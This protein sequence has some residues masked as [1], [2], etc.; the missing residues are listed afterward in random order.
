MPPAA[1]P[2]CPHTLKHVSS[3]CADCSCSASSTILARAAVSRCCRPPNRMF[4][5]CSTLAARLASRSI[6][7]RAES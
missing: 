5:L 3:I 6:S 7:D 1:P 2:V 4:T